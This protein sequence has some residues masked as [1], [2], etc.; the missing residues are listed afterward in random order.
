MKMLIAGAGL[1]GRAIAFDLLRFGK[2]IEIGLA[3]AYVE[4][5]NSAVRLLERNCSTHLLDCT[6]ESDVEDIFRGYDLV[7]SALPYH[8]NERLAALAVR[9]RSH[10]I[11]LGG[12]SRIVRKEMELYRHAHDAKVVVIPDCGLAP[13]LSNIFAMDGYRKLD[14]VFEMHARVGG[15]PAQPKPPLLYQLVFSA[16]GLLNEYTEPVEI[17][18]DGVRRIVDPMTALEEIRFDEVEGRLEAFYTS[19]GLS[20]LPEKLEGK[21]DEL[22]YKTIR[23]AGHCERFKM[24]LDLGFAGN[25]PVMVGGGIHTSRELFAE[26][27][28]RK[29]SGEDADMVL[30]RVDILG[31][32]EGD[33]IRIRY[34]LT[35]HYDKARNMSAMMRTTAFPVSITALAIADGGM[36]QRGSFLPH[37]FLNAETMIAELQKRDIVVNVTEVP[38]A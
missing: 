22:S 4:Q 32:R 33:K 38:V 1:M 16:E 5:L 25:D 11:D 28:R 13:G 34:E 23:H 37:D 27:L 31:K 19:G 35:D 21:L 15:I 6:H 17:I 36:K 26:L 20:L 24:L 29:L 30:C 7:I 9:S 18:T 3:D 10:F 12:N 14:T 8:L 2:G